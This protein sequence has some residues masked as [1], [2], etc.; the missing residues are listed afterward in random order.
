LETQT[1]AIS[2]IEMT[3]TVDYSET[4]AV[5]YMTES[6]FQQTTNPKSVYATA[7]FVE[8]ELNKFAHVLVEREDHSL[9]FDSSGS[10]TNF[11]SIL[12]RVTVFG[13]EGNI[14]LSI[15]DDNLGQ[16]SATI[17]HRPRAIAQFLPIEFLRSFP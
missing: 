13:K 7:Q 11:F 3:G 2:L 16:I 12:Y 6:G 5:E 17:V 10:E 15:V 9:A 8:D 1:I 4:F 14:A